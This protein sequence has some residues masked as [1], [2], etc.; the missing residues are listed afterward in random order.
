MKEQSRKR[1]ILTYFF[2]Q[3]PLGF[4]LFLMLGVTAFIVV[5][6]SIKIPVYNTV[7]AYV[8]KENDMIRLNLHNQKIQADTPVFLYQSRDDFLEKITEYQLEDGYIV[9]DDTGVFLNGEKINIDFQTEEVTLLRHIL[10][11]GN[12]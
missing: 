2:V 9:T 12:T 7:E 8:E 1:K 11:G 5:T 6:G 4:V 10:E 3:K